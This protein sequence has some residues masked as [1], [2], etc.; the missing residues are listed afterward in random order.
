MKKAVFIVADKIKDRDFSPAIQEEIGKHVDILYPFLNKQNYTEH[1]D[2]IEQADIIFSGIGAPVMDKTFLDKAPHLEAIF[3]AAGTMKHIFTDE[4]VWKRDITVTNSNYP[5]AIP[6]AEFTLAQILL[7]LKNSWFLARKVREEK[8]FTNGIDYSIAGV[9]NSTV[10][11]ISYSTIGKMVVDLLKNFQVDIAMYDPFVTEE[12]AKEIGVQL[13]SL[14]EI[15]EISDVVSLHAPRLPET[16]DMITGEHI[17]SMKTNATFINTARGEIVREQEMIEVLQERSDLTALLDVTA[18]EPPESDSPLYTM[19]NVFLT[20][21]I[22]G[23]VGKERQRL[24]EYVLEE[25]KRYLAGEPL[26]FEVTKEL[27]SNMA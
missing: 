27:F 25:L 23:S 22:A 9:Y 15:F 19:D 16:L 14:D 5:N 24:G 18:P 11:I 26:R 17:R 10:G 4:E 13:C 2:M 12:Q 1:W 8:H 6:V 7:S 21:H 3:Y 20:P